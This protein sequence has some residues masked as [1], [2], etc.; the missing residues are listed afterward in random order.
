MTTI[1]LF[2]AAVM[3]AVLAIGIWQQKHKH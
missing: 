2:I 3:L 1:A